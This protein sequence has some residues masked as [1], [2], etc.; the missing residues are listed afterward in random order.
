M[1]PRRIEATNFGVIPHAEVDL[2]NITLAAICGV[3]GAGKST[4]FTI[5][6]LFALFGVTKNGCSVDDMV[7]AGQSEMSITLEFEHRGEIYRVIRTRS[8]KGR[9]KSSLELQKMVDARW[10]GES[11]TTIRETEEKIKALLNLDTETFTTSS[12]ILQGKANEFTSKSPGQRK[13]ILAQILGLDIYEKLQDKSREK[14]RAVTVE[15]EKLKVKLADIDERIKDLPGCK[16]KLK[17]IKASIIKVTAELKEKEDILQTHEDDL[18]HLQIIG[19]KVHDIDKNVVDIN[20]AKE[21]LNIEKN[22]LNEKQEKAQK[23]LEAEEKIIAKAAEYERLKQQSIVLQAQKPRLAEISKERNTLSTEIQDLN[24]Q[25]DEINKKIVGLEK[26]LSNRTKYEKAAKDH[27]KVL[28]EIEVMDKLY[29]QKIELENKVQIA[30]NDYE[31]K[32]IEIKV[33]VKEL[34]D[35]INRLSKKAEMLDK[36]GCID[37]KRARCKFL[38]DAREAKEQLPHIEVQ[39][40]SYDGSQTQPYLEKYQATKKELENLKYD[41][42]KHKSFKAFEV[43]LRSMAQVAAEIEARAEYLQSLK[44][45]KNKLIQQ[46]EKSSQRLNDLQQQVVALEN[47]IHLLELILS[48]LPKL[49]QW[50]KAK[51][52]LPVA[53]Q[54]LITTAE[55]LE[56]IK[57][58]IKDKI[59]ELSKLEDE[60]K[61]CIKDFNRMDSV[62]EAIAS[63]KNEIEKLHSTEKELYGNEGS[64]RAK[65]ESLTKDESKKKELLTEIDPLAKRLAR[66][67]TLIKAFG[68]DGIPALIIENAIPE[69][70][71]IANEILG[72]MTNGKHTIRFETQRDLKSKAGMAETLDIIIGDWLGERPYETYSG[73][74]QLRIDFAIRFALAE[75]LAR[76]AGSKVEWLT[77]D[78]GLGSQDEEHRTLVLEAIKAVANRFKKVLVITH[79]GEA[80]A[81]FDQTIYFEPTEGSIDITV[82]A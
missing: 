32:D 79:I 1:I 16:N 55:R 12:M 38:I 13:A 9:G 25:L 45:Q 49:Q 52:E 39:L 37:P 53:R 41:V 72:Q 78:E 3:N 65:I 15:L 54:L 81:A 40:K 63:C 28:E 4:L 61:A 47:E 48:R 21:K 34:K 56:M 26:V 51:E 8:M 82:A 64:I 2:T 74:E 5:A 60:K 43:E 59:S 24:K 44:E 46:K 31:K 62:K 17:D 27:Q 77:I 80:Q 42:E 29:E 69:L 22:N 7:R 71:R 66:F 20:A 75:L 18:K 50:A 68:R 58:D 70:E 11:G 14:A 6:P 57:A 76:R 73:G 30:K 19:L 36:S 33:Q 23:M 67:E 35:E 10:A